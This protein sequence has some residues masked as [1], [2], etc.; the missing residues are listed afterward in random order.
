MEYP[1]EQ[2]TSKY[3]QA[4]D[5]MLHQAIVSRLIHLPNRPPHIGA[6]LKYKLRDEWIECL[7]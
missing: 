1:S 3:A 2:L 4:I 7:F 6:A 5:H